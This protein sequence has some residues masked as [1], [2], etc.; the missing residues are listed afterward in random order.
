MTATAPESFEVI[1]PSVT[2]F[3]PSSGS[4]YATMTITGTNFIDK[5]YTGNKGGNTSVSFSDFATGLNSRT[6][7][8]TSI[9]DTQIT[10]IVPQL[11]PGTYKV[12]VGVQ[13]S[14]V[15]AEAAFT[16]EE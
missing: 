10:V 12:T 14:Y 7:L 1:V 2:S 4:Q 11:W 16:Y 15:S 6:G 9:T 13:A 8:V 5:N 3:T